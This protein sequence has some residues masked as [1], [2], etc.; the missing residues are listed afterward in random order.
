VVCGSVGQEMERASR[1][2]LSAFAGICSKERNLGGEGAR[3]VY[4]RAILD[5]FLMRCLWV[6]LLSLVFGVSPAAA[7]IVFD[8]SSDPMVLGNDAYY[9]IGISRVNGAI[10]YIHDRIS[11][12]DISPGNSHDD[13]WWVKH[14]ASGLVRS[15]TFSPTSGTH[16]F[17]YA[18]DAG[19]SIL[20]LL[21]DYSGSGET[22]RVTVELSAS[23]ANL[24]DIRA[25]VENGSDDPITIVYVPS[26]LS[27]DMNEVELFYFPYYEG[28]AFKRSFF[29]E[30]RST[31]QKYQHLFADFAALES[32]QGNMALYALP[33]EGTFH[34]AELGLGYSS[35]SG[36]VSVYHHMFHTWIEPSQPWMSPILRLRVGSPILQ[37]LAD[38]RADRGWD[39]LRDLEEKAGD[40]YPRLSDAV[41]VKIDCQHVYDWGWAGSGSVFGWVDSVAAELSNTALLHPV[42]FWSGGFDNNY[43][44]YLP[45]NAD[46]GSEAEFLSILDNAGA[47]GQLVMPYT[48]PTWWDEDS[49]TVDSLGL[50]IA[51]RDLNGNPVQECYG[52]NCG[53]VVSPADPRVSQRQAATV[54]DFTQTY[55]CD[56]LFE[57]QVADRPWTYDTHPEEASY[58]S[59][60]DALIENAATSSGQIPLATEGML[61]ALLD[62]E[63]MF[64]DSVML[65]KKAGWI[66]SWGNY[67]WVVFPLTMLT[68]HDKIAFY[69]HNLAVEV[70]TDNKEMLTYNLAHG[71]GLGFDL[72]GEPGM[73]NSEWL[74][75]DESFQRSVAAL[76]CG[77]RMTEFEFLDIDR[78][79]TRSVFEDVEVVG[80]HDTDTYDYGDH[81]IASRG[82]CATSINGSLLAGVFTRFNGLDLGGEHF[83]VQRKTGRNRYAVEQ[84]SGADVQLRILKPSS[85]VFSNRVKVVGMC[86]DGT[87]VDLTGYPSTDVQD[88]Y[89]EFFW[90]RD[91]GGHT[92]DFYSV[93]Y[94][95]SGGD[96]N[97]GDVEEETEDAVWLDRLKISSYPNPTAGSTIVNLSLP[98][99]AGGNPLHAAVYSTD[100]RRVRLLNAGWVYSREVRLIWDGTDENG[101]PVASGIYFL[102]VRSRDHA[103]SSKLVLM[104]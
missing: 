60:T 42:S 6:S 82:L 55:P 78:T 36:G 50:D 70:M 40:L 37:T 22:L 38:Y 24:L 59:Y 62:I 46:Y 1:E 88:G 28:V 80:N 90:A 14:R 16:V 89:V 18:W 19:Q 103:L 29:Q 25:A 71:F 41:L 17:S 4:R 57:D 45:P 26:Q 65:D 48:N 98:A 12:E 51:A 74:R 67:N 15:S 72:T 5:F 32:T 49:P 102:R 21:Y 27:F 66:S 58:T 96:F 61:D 68:A 8:D 99:H 7:V 13:L 2:A 64:F 33:E 39:V 92:V 77:K 35:W 104:R 69:Q 79:V 43:P 30:L 54:Q 52:A 56:L 3:Q 91:L 31:F 75:I 85:W 86:E 47:R 53:Y 11:G 20:T 93:S 9:E 87:Q 101:A 76:C 95:N 63:M 84:P 44:D 81:R 23:E 83:L 34:P 100:G 73:V 10:T 94:G 97:V